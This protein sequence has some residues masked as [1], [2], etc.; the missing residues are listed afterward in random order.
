MNRIFD[1]S[2]FFDTRFRFELSRHDR[3][4]FSREKYE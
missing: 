1:N 3:I 2:N 4:L